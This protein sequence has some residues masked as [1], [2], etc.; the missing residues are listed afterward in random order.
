VVGAKR[1]WRDGSK[2]ANACGGGAL[3]SCWPLPLP[4][5][6]HCHLSGTNLDHRFTIQ[7]LSDSLTW[8]GTYDQPASACRHGFVQLQCQ[9]NAPPQIGTWHWSINSGP[10]SGTTTAQD[11][12]TA[13]T[14]GT[15]G[16]W[17]LEVT[18]PQHSLRCQQG[19]AT[20]TYLTF[21]EAAPGRRQLTLVH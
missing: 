18:L 6:I 10:D 19:G 15:A 7:K 21:S 3:T 14:P 11:S 17:S 8:Q 16:P 13:T 12:G 2:P 9:A 4:L 1:A 20:V 5:T